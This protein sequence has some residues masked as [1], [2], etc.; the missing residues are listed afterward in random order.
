MG[1]FT[2]LVKL[3]FLRMG[4]WANLVKQSTSV[5]HPPVEKDKVSLT[6]MSTLGSAANLVPPSREIHLMPSEGQ[7]PTPQ[8]HALS[9]SPLL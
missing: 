9:P 4:V 3:R 8:L 6:A 5:L 2:P 7:E 1:S